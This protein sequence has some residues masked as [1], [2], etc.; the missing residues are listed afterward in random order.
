V[1]V[2]RANIDSLHTIRN[3]IVR[4]VKV[5]NATFENV[6]RPLANAQHAVEESSGMIAVLRYAS[7]EAAARKAAEQARNL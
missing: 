7:P 6:V 3:E 5:E 1:N 4:D 2:T